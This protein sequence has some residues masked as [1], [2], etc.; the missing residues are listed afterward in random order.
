MFVYDNKIDPWI[1]NSLTTVNLGLKYKFGNKFD[2][3]AGCNDIFN[4]SP[5]QAVVISKAYGPY[6]YYN[7]DYPLQGRTYYVSMQYKF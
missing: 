7:T 1:Q 3:A 4:R 6:S 5:K 2:F